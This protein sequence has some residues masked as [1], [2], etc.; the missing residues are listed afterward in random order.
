ML[1]L[2][3]PQMQANGTVRFDWPTVV[4]RSYRLE[5]SID[6]RAWQ[7][8]SEATRAT[9][10]PLSATLPALDP[11]LPYFFRVVVTP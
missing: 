1:R 11:Q 9:G 7:A 3:L 10:D 5:T 2:S 6:L 4:G 8:V